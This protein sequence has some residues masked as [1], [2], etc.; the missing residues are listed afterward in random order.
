MKKK[1]FVICLCIILIAITVV[2][3]SL[4]YF[5]DS[6]SS[7]VQSVVVGNVKLKLLD[8]G[9][10]IETL[11]HG[12]VIVPGSSF[13]KTLTVSNVGSCDAYVRLHIDIAEDTNRLF[14]FQ[15]S[16]D[17][18]IM[19]GDDPTKAMLAP[20]SPVA[21]PV[22][23][24]STGSYEENGVTYIR[25]TFTCKAP[26]M[27]GTVS[28]SPCVSMKLRD[29]LDNADF[30]NMGDLVVHFV[31]EGIQTSSAFSSVQEAFV[32]FEIEVNNP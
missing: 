5:T 9:R 4:A 10:D 15:L 13:E 7:D 11:H 25:H 31:M 29:E 20:V 6:D 32:A 27:Q 2:F 17:V 18:S 3:G 21:D 19:P 28:Q 30:E 12:E 8:T 24:Y 1:I 14:A 16:D 26:L 22:F 23:V